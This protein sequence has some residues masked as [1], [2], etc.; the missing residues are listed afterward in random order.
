MS[1]NIRISSLTMEHTFKAYN[2]YLS[3]YRTQNLITDSF[4]KI[5]SYSLIS[6]RLAT[7][8]TNGSVKA[9]ITV[10]I[11]ASFLTADIPVWF[12][13]LINSTDITLPKSRTY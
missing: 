2:I 1:S 6:I 4:N 10:G 11:D 9:Y 5:T 7:V 8:K 12:T 13:G 3:N